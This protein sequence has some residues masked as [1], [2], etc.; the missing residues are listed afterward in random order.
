MHEA[1]ARGAQPELFILGL[2]ERRKRLIQTRGEAAVKAEKRILQLFLGGSHWLGRR[3][4][5]TTKHEG[6]QKQIPY[7][8]S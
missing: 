2:G 6:G 8:C 1:V 3:C 4:V 5:C 7:D